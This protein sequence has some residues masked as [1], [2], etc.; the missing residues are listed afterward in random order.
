MVQ[1]EGNASEPKGLDLKRYQEI[2]FAAWP[3]CK[4]HMNWPDIAYFV[5]R[6]RVRPS[7]ETSLKPGNVFVSKLAGEWTS[8]LTVLVALVIQSMRPQYLPTK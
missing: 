3:E 2:Y 1:F 6:P 4:P 5:V 8:T 7:Q